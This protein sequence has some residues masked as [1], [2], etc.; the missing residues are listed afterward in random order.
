MRVESVAGEEAVCVDEDGA[1]HESVAVDLMG[2]VA[3]GDR[4]LVHAGVAIGALEGNHS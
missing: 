1:R 4:L 2:P 3:S